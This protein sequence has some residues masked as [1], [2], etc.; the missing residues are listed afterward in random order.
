MSDLFNENTKISEKKLF[1]DS[2]I[3]LNPKDLEANYNRFIKR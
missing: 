2:T 1:D 3:Q